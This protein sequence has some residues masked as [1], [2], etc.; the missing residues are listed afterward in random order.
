MLRLDR[1]ASIHRRTMHQESDLTPEAPTFPSTC[2]PRFPSIRRR[3]SEQSLRRREWKRKKRDQKTKGQKK[4]SAIFA[5]DTQR[6]VVCNFI[7]N[8]RQSP[9]PVAP[10]LFVRASAV[11]SSQW[12]CCGA[13]YY[14]SCSRHEVKYILPGGANAPHSASIIV[15]AAEDFSLSLAFLQFSIGRPPE[16]TPRGERYTLMFCWTQGSVNPG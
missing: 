7:V 8:V 12:I 10:V 5:E 2:C 13:C 9:L 14:C 6:R 11:S 1:T 4:Y 16:E 3:V 15:S